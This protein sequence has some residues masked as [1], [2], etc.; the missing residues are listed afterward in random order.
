MKVK[1]RLGAAAIFAATA[2]FAFLVPG[3]G[4]ASSAVRGSATETAASVGQPISLIGE[5]SDDI[6][7]EIPAWS[8]EL[9]GRTG[10]LSLSYFVVGGLEGRADYIN[11][12]GDFVVSGVPWQPSELAQ[13][14][15]TTGGVISAPISVSAVGF[16]LAWGPPYTL[17]RSCRQGDASCTSSSNYTGALDIPSTSLVDMMWPPIVKNSA[18]TCRCLSDPAILAATAG[19]IPQGND[20]APP[21][22]SVPSVPST[23]ALLRSE[24]SET[25]YYLQ[26]FA[27]AAAPAE[28]AKIPLFT[29]PITEYLQGEESDTRTVTQQGVQSEVDYMTNEG[30]SV[31]ADN[32]QGII[33][34]LPPSGLT[35]AHYYLPPGLT[36]NGTPPANPPAWIAVENA[37]GQWVTPNPASINAAVDAGG[38]RPLYALSNRVPGTTPAYPLTY[39]NSLTAPAHG[40][41]ADQAEAIATVIRYGATAGQDAM[42]PQ[43]D[44]QLPA[45]LVQQALTAANQLIASNCTSSTEQVVVSDSIGR[46]APVIGPLDGKSAGQRQAELSAI[47]PML[48]CQAAAAP[49]KPGVPV[50]GTAPFTAPPTGP[51]SIS[52]GPSGS[53]SSAQPGS[54]ASNSAQAG[55]NPAAPGAGGSASASHATMNSPSGGSQSTGNGGSGPITLLSLPLPLPWTGGGGYDRLVG[56]VLGALAFLLLW[57]SRDALTRLLRP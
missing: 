56:M 35:G 24:P 14:P 9:F 41:S 12:I 16:G 44:G 28:F 34:P 23:I 22:L 32:L 40:L 11:G 53:S 15:A 27:Q 30:G 20:T 54:G 49:A 6:A 48:H 10:S 46:Y 31:V 57:R 39:V 45:S 7:R 43:N 18:A 55:T 2:I 21:S 37:S 50:P 3:G 8:N 17:N 47:G 5:G 1:F 51:G 36:F 42:P 26:A 29:P 25:S 13:L 38:A 19:Q 52:G 4:I 33:A